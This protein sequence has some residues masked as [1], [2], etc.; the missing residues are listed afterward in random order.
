MV[1]A[2]SIKKWLHASRAEDAARQRTADAA[3]VP[4]DGA[5]DERQAE[6]PARPSQAPQRARARGRAPT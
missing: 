5:Q 3:N 1:N 6:T 2:M 4:R